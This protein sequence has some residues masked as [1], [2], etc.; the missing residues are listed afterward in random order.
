MNESLVKQLRKI[1]PLNRGVSEIYI[2]KAADEI[3]RLE[4][5]LAEAR[6]LIGKQTFTEKDASSIAAIDAAIKDQKCS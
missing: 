6:K 2:E 3:E 5:L 4:G 1:A